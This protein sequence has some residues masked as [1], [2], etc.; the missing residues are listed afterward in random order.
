MRMEP[1]LKILKEMGRKL[2]R[3]E[4]HQYMILNSLIPKARPTKR[5]R[6]AIEKFFIFDLFHQTGS[7]S[8]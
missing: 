3:M 1:D 8:K 7:F 2:E 5:E 6:Q 4:L